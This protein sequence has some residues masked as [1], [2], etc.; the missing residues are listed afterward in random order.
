MLMARALS[1]PSTRTTPA[2][3]P[4]RTDVLVRTIKSYC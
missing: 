2:S 3:D 4:G 1:V